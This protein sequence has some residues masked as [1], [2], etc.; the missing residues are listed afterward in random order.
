MR[1]VVQEKNQD[2]L[3]QDTLWLMF[4]ESF[5]N[6][7]GFQLHHNGDRQGAADK[8]APGDESPGDSLHAIDQDLYD[9]VD[10]TA[11][12]S[13]G[14]EG[15][16]AY[17][18]RHI[19]TLA[20][21]F[22]TNSDLRHAIRDLIAVGRK[23]IRSKTPKNQAEAEVVAETAATATPS[24]LGPAPAAPQFTTL[25]E[26]ENDEGIPHIPG[27][28]GPDWDHSD[29]DSDSDGEDLWEVPE[30]S[31]VAMAL[32]NNPRAQDFIRNFKAAVYVIT[33]KRH[34]TPQNEHT[35]AS[36]IRRVNGVAN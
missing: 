16:L 30:E 26:H 7:T 14:R 21:I 19:R 17:G 9:L 24:D 10:T 28:W 22:L 25:S 13:D 3:F 12:E 8:D 4:V 5:P 31:P 11:V 20:T 36:R 1:V 18:A 35:G 23:L 6:V 34:L 29:S 32:K 15:E 2:E 27:A 33:P